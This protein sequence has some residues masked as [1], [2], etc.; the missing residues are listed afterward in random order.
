MI[1]KN[2]LSKLWQYMWRSM[3][4]YFTH[5]QKQEDKMRTLT[6]SVEEL[7]YLEQRL[8]KFLKETPEAYFVRKRCE[9][10]C[11]GRPLVERVNICLSAIRSVSEIN[12]ACI[13]YMQRSTNVGPQ[14]YS[15]V[16]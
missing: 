3:W 11:S 16:S 9:K 6:M 4:L 13:A 7:I 10:E 2:T 12:K 15:P 8:W 1:T 5:Y 14:D